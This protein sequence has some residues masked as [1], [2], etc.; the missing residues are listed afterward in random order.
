MRGNITSL[1]LWH[2]GSMKDLVTAIA[3]AAAIVRNQ[4]DVQAGA[5]RVCVEGEAPMTVRHAE[6]IRELLPD[7]SHV[8][9]L[10]L[11]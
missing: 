1:G 11:S 10:V 2:I 6:L 5:I 7:R 4:D 8:Y 9:D 3:L